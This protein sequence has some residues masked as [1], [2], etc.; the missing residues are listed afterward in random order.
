MAD[1]AAPRTRRLPR[2]E[3]ATASRPVPEKDDDQVFAFELH[4]DR[5]FL[6]GVAD[7]ITSSNGGAAARWVKVAMQSIAAKIQ[8]DHPVRLPNARTLFR[9]FSA[10]LSEQ[11]RETRD[12]DSHS[13]LTCGIGR[14]FPARSANYLRFDFFGIG[15]SPAW[16]VVPCRGKS[17]LSFQVSPVYSPPVP[18][19]QGGVY[20]WVDLGAGRVQGSVHFGSVHV[21]EGELLIVASDG[22]PE[23]RLIFDDQDPDLCLGSPKLIEALLRS[24]MLS[25]SILDEAIAAYDAAH[26]LI[27]DDASLAVARW[28]F[29]SV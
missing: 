8:A 2:I 4:P 6:I 11:A 7:G 12:G 24:C 13:T 10:L 27:D 1:A 28:R 29:S 5:S 9:R 26:L 20:S 25:D 15:D 14:L 16:R 23:S 18:S 3:L 17:L 19:E 22:L 21:E